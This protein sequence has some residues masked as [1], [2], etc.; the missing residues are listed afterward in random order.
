MTC[1]KKTVYHKSDV[2]PGGMSHLVA[3]AAVEV[4]YLFYSEPVEMTPGVT[5]K[6]TIRPLSVLLQQLVVY[7]DCV[8]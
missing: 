8:R 2:V 6:E 4:G 7:R 1:E 5:V 3:A